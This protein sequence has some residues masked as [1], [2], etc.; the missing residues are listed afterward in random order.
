MPYIYEYLVI[1]EVTK[2]PDRSGRRIRTIKPSGLY[3]SSSNTVVAQ[4]LFEMLVV[5][6]ICNRKLLG[7]PGEV[8]P[9]THK[10]IDWNEAILSG[11]AEIMII[12][13]PLSEI[14]KVGGFFSLLPADMYHDLSTTWKKD[15]RGNSICVVSD[16]SGFVDNW[17]SISIANDALQEDSLQ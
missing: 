9:V 14:N 17:L 5:E 12:A 3:I 7:K 11:V 4:G 8:T 6:F 13:S 2:I 1:F 15:H 16:Q 10:G